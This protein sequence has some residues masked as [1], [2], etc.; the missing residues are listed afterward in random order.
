M[1]KQASPAWLDG[2]K[3][4]LLQLRLDKR[5]H[6]FGTVTT[7]YVDIQRL[8]K[9]QDN[10][11][12]VCMKGFCFEDEATSW[13]HDSE[14]LKQ[15]EKLQIV[16]EYCPHTLDEFSAAQHTTADV[17]R[18]FDELCAGVELMHAKDLAH[19]DLEPRN[20]L[21]TEDRHIRLT[22]FGSARYMFGGQHDTAELTVAYAAPEQLGS[23]RK[24]RLCISL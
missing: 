10:P 17:L 9:H 4:A 13:S 23:Q 14:G 22:D 18:M 16:V 8:S 7:F 20:V 3:V 6:S 1:M 24:V 12:V 15:D 21:V 19:G 2:A 11:Y 5:S